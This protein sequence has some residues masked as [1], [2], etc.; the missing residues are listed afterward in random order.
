M[1]DQKV[2]YQLTYINNFED[3]PAPWKK[4]IHALNIHWQVERSTRHAIIHT[5]LAK[6]NA[7]VVSDHAAE[8]IH[9]EFDSEEDLVSW[10]ITHS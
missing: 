3:C 5:Q 1:P 9:V 10:L 2:R 7:H 8:W 6:W 4:F